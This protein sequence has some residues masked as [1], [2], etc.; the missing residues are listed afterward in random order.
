MKE[1]E[2]KSTSK[3]DVDLNIDFKIPSN[4]SRVI[5]VIS[6]YITLIITILIIL[7]LVF[8]SSYLIT[9]HL[10]IFVLADDISNDG[11]L[12]FVSAIVGIITSFLTGAYIFDVLGKYIRQ[13]NEYIRTGKFP[14]DIFD[15]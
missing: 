4:T 1:L 8:S 7:L 15:K 12:L 10:L 2:N 9:K 3:P 5:G 13:V 11:V 14:H 6:R